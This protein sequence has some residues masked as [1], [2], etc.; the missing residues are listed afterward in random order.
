MVSLD[1]LTELKQPLKGET[2]RRA[3]E[4]R[5]ISLEEFSRKTGMTFDQIRAV[6]VGEESCLRR[7]A[8]PLNWYAK[9]YAKKLGF[10]DALNDQVIQSHSSTLKQTHLN[11]S[12]EIPTFL[13]KQVTS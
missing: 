4:A 9:I 13:K 12:P 8:K 1:C 3:R 10:H 2:L 11:L 5:G 6:E 7:S